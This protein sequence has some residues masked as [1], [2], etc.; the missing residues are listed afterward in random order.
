MSHRSLCDKITVK[1]YID[2]LN[3][4]NTLLN[5]YFVAKNIIIFNFE[6]TITSNYILVI[7]SM[8]FFDAAYYFIT[9]NFH[10]AFIKRLLRFCV[11]HGE[12]IKLSELIDS[13]YR[14]RCFSLKWC[15]VQY[16]QN[17]MSSMQHYYLRYAVVKC[18]II[19]YDQV[20]MLRNINCRWSR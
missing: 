8:Q 10:F 1:K 3:I 11:P 4:L 9:S 17:I 12:I 13:N 15:Y 18:E 20:R 5:I 16:S 6:S 7:C 19:I 2:I 14:L